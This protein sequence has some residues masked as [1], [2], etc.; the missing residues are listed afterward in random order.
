MPTRRTW[1]CVKPK[2][3]YIRDP[4]VVIPLSR[5]IS[6]CTLPTGRRTYPFGTEL[7]KALSVEKYKTGSFNASTT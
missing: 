3:L 1:S 2:D 7:K 6:R 5:P 4:K